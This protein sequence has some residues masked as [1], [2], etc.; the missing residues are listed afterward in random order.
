M[1]NLAFGDGIESLND[2]AV[3]GNGDTDKI[4]ATVATA[5]EQFLRMHPTAMLYAVGSTPARTRLYRSGFTRFLSRIHPEFLL[6]GIVN[7]EPELFEP[8]RP[9][10]A[11]VI[12]RNPAYLF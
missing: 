8:G 2:L 1:Y 3:S 5:A 11:F 7:N 10:E 6:F 9:Y 4:L 12:Q